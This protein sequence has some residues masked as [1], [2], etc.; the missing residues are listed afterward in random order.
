MEN[1]YV[2]SHS[3]EY[4]S[5]EAEPPPK[6]E[7]LEFIYNLIRGISRH[8]HIHVEYRHFDSSIGIYIKDRSSSRSWTFAFLIN[9]ELKLGC[10]KHF[11]TRM[12]C[13]EVDLERISQALEGI[14]FNVSE[15]NNLPALLMKN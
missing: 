5:E 10:N 8:E 2:S 3:A 14:G 4:L 9:S 12:G 11:A 7:N 13:S 15:E 6:H 1:S